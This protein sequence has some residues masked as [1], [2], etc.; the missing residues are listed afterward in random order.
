M[1]G[2]NKGYGEFR[3][4][5]PVVLAAMLGIG[6]GLSPVPIYTTGALAPHLA[7]AFGW[8][9]GEIMAGLTVMTFTVL[10]ASPVVGL[11][12]DRYG[13]R[14][15]ALTSVVLFGLSFMGFAFSNGSLP[16]YYATW[17]VMAVA[18]AGTLPVTWTRAVNNR[19]ETRKGLALG[20]ALLGTG[21]FG[22][23]V[24]PLTAWL[25][26]EFGWRGAYVAIGALPLLGRGQHQWR[27]NGVACYLF[28]SCHRLFHLHYWHIWHQN[29]AHWAAS[30]V[31]P[32]AE[33]LSTIPWASK[34]LRMRSA[35]AKFL[36]ALAAARAAI[37]A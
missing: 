24:K 32:A 18:G 7:Q 26:V 35:S 5:W 13:V 28:R 6:L 10:I 17:A 16:L 3:Q 22:Y 2:T 27:R 9:F 25:V 12:A 37:C 19:F 21:L 33:S 15:V 23:L 36:A 1:S 29:H 30:Q 34:W 31:V 11:L 14:P 20:L 4:G 8:G